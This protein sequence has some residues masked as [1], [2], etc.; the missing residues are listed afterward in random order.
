LRSFVA[1]RIAWTNGWSILFHSPSVFQERNAHD[2]M[3]DFTQEIQ[4]YLHNRKIA[5]RLDLLSLRSGVANLSQNLQLCYEEL[6]HLGMVAH[7]EPKLLEAWLVDVAQLQ[8]TYS[9]D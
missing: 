9:R 3:S 2:L 4:G 5:E 6:A 1:Q 8:L 7:S